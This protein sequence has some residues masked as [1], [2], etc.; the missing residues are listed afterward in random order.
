[1]NDLRR[2]RV[3]FTRMVVLLLAKAFELGYEATIGD[4]YRDPRCPYGSKNSLHRSGLAVDINLYRDGVYL[5]KTE[6]HE[7][8]GVYWESIGG[9]WGGRFADGNHY[10]L[11][12]GGKR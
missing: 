11:S 8:L 4:V 12:W 7:P 5:D 3:E 1:M 2:R 6:D 9:S 10:S